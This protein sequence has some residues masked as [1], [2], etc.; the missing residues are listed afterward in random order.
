MS[1]EFYYTNKAE[2][3]TIGY[4]S[5]RALRTVRKYLKNKYVVEKLLK[6]RIR[7]SEVDLSRYVTGKVLPSPQK[8][9]KILR[10]LHETGLIKEVFDKIVSIDERGVVSIS[11]VAFDMDILM[12]ATSLAYLYFAGRVDKVVTAAVNGIPLASTI[13]TFLNTELAVAKREREGSSNVFIEKNVFYS[14]PPNLVTFYLPKDS[15]KK[16]DRILV[17]DDLIRTGRTLRVLLDIAS[18]KEALIE[19]VF[20]LIALGSGWKMWVPENAKVLVLY[21]IK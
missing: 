2:K 1:E 17:V 9:A 18:E 13:A 21:E 20:S 8:S 12:L 14:D 7:I 5:Y 11:R 19:G 16:N 15:I 4:L 3:G 6:Y 10:A